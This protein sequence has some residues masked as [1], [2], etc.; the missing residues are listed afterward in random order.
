MRMYALTAIEWRL[1]EV[2]RHRS[3]LR[4]GRDL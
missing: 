1:R 4:R 2:G 3:P